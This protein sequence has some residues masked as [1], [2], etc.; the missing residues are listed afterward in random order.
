MISDKHCYTHVFSR[1]RQLDALTDC[2]ID[3]ID[4][5]ESIV[6]RKRMCYN[7]IPVDEDEALTEHC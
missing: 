5:P 6:L 1:G 3:H 2:L 7:E 4:N